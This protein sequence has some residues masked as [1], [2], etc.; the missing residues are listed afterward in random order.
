MVANKGKFKVGDRVRV[1]DECGGGKIG[2]IGTVTSVDGDYYEIDGLSE[3]ACGL[4]GYRLEPIVEQAMAAASTPKFKVGD[5][6]VYRNYMGGED[7][8]GTVAKLKGDFIYAEDWSV[9][10]SRGDLSANKLELVEPNPS[11]FAFSD[12]RLV[13]KA[14][15]FTCSS[16]TKPAIVC[17]IENGQP[18]P[19]D[20][21]H[22][23]ADRA[24]AA[25]EASRLAKKHTGKRFGVYELVHAAKEEP[26][27][28][29][30]RL[31]V[32]GRKLDAIR[33]LRQLSGIGFGPALTSVNRIADGRAA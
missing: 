17:L 12:G 24:S 8:Y 18:R 27:H 20:E 1:V 23:H 30:Q 6:V 10:I 11:I 14:G 19:S 26:E 21:P 3:G 5:R 16:P 4:F 7:C 31:A 15:T 33:E 2:D 13:I 9:G 29:W 22:V 28:E 32:A 25:A